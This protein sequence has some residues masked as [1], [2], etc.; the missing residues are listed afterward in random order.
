MVR[1]RHLVWALGETGMSTKKTRCLIVGM[2]G[3]SRGTAP[4]MKS[5]EWFEAADVKVKIPMLGSA[6]S[7]NVAQSATILMYEALRQ[8]S[9]VG[10]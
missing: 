7:L 6:D 5:K 10:K 4:A 9:I 2:G 1:A 3:I 8:R